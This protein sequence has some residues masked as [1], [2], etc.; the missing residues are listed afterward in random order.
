MSREQLQTWAHADT[1]LQQ[2]NQIIII[3]YSF[4]VADEHFNDLLRQ[5]RGTTRIVVVNPELD[6]TLARASAV[7][8]IAPETL[9][10]EERGGFEVRSSQRLTGIRANAEDLDGDVLTVALQ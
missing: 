10:S 6:G 5:T 7:L 2:A 1:L 9:T 3:G 8:G 4:A